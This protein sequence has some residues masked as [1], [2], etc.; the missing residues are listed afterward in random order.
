M[1]KLLKILF[2][3]A[4][5]AC[6]IVLAL[7]NRQIVTISLLTPELAQFTGFSWQMDIPL[8][9]VV[10]GGIAAGLLIGFIWEWLRETKHRREVAKRQR[11]V[12]QLKQQVIQLKGEKNA[13]RDEVLAL[14]DDQ[15]KKAG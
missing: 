12:K 7:A 2:L 9:F 15:P 1:I 4:L 5:A 13:G 6:L 3:A 8:Y 11:E 10:F 14:L